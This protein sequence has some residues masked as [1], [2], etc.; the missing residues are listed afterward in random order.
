LIRRRWS[1]LAFALLL[2]AATAGAQTFGPNL[3]VNHGGDG[4]N[5]NTPSVELGPEGQVYIL[6]EDWRHP[7]GSATFTRSLDNGASFESERRV[8][9]EEAPGYPPPMLVKW[10]CLAI[11]GPGIIYVVWVAWEPG[12]TGRVW[13]ARSSDQG[14]S[15]SNPVLVSD[16]TINDR[17]WPAAAGDPAGGVHIVWCDFRNGDEV[18]DLY[19]SYSVDGTAFST[20]VKA[21]VIPVGPT[22]TPPLPDIAVAHT[23]SGIVHI[24]WRHTGSANRRYV[25]ACRSLD[26]GRSFRMPVEVS[27]DVWVFDG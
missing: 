27:H 3:R 22:C 21:N 26:G 2:A 16:S 4:F 12:Q 15:F 24:V 11:D 23:T 19:T 13:C 18:V 10:P 7:T 1:Y 9:P 25:Y 20:N 14:V 8:D 5:Q 17:A 6:W